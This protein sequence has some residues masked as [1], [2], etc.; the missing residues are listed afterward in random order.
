MFKKSAILI[1]LKKSESV[2]SQP[3]DHFRLK[4]YDQFD[5][6]S[7]HI[8]KILYLLFILTRIIKDN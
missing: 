4:T 5:L 3:S 2:C 6:S 8:M 7:T 1:T